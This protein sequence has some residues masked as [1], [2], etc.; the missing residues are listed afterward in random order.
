MMVSQTCSLS[1]LAFSTGSSVQQN[2]AA[3]GFFKLS[4]AD[5]P[6]DIDS[7]SGRISLPLVVGAED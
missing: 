2:N 3:F 6:V 4:T 5:E 1:R 7:F